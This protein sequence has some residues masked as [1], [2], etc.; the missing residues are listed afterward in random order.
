MVDVCP[1]GE[2]R[3]DEGEYLAAGSGTADMTS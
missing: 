3:G 2:E 1:S